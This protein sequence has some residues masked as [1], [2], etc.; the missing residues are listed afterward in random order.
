MNIHQIYTD[1]QLRNFTYIIQLSN[2]SA[3]VVDPWD[4]EVINT[5]LIQNSLSLSTIINTHEHWDHTKG[6]SALVSQHGCEVW[7]H[8]NGLGKIPGLSRQLSGHEKIPLESDVYI[9]VIDTPGHSQAHL[10][11][12]VFI[13]DKPE[14]IFSGDILF[15][16]GVGNCHNG[17]VFD[18][19]KTIQEKFETLA[20][21][22]II[23]PGH[24]YLENNLNFTLSR[25]PS[26]SMAKHWLEKYHQSDIF[27]N[28]LQTTMADERQINTFFRLN[29]QEIRNNLP[30][31]P[32]T[33]K[34][35]FVSLRSCR[36][37]W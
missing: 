9:E 15:N 5:F 1:N 27:T 2:G 10:C 24:D 30:N 11:F 31:K 16:A 23:L 7:A 12:I 26:N 37:N 3:I 8:N 32:Q 14:Y 13:H 21:N 25:E 34:D 4:A 33:E 36:D 19:F 20:D 17:N 18:L 35:V 6:N 28:P 22:I 29:N